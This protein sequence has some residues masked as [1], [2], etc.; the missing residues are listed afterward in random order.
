MHFEKIPSEII[1][2]LQVNAAPSEDREVELQLAV[3][4]GANRKWSL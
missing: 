2:K 1:L 3:S 4:S